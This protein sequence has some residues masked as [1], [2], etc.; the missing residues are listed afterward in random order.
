M[1]KKPPIPYLSLMRTISTLMVVLFH[2][3]YSFLEFQ[4]PGTTIGYFASPFGNWGAPFVSVFFM[5]SGAS[6]IYNHD[7]F[8]GIKDVLRFWWKRFL[9]L[10]PMFYTAWLVMYIINSNKFGSWF[11]GG[12]RRNFL[13]TLLGM[14]G[15]LMHHGRNY[16]C[17]GEW[18]LGAIIILYLLYPLLTF[19]FNHL[20]IPSTVLVVLLYVLNIN[21]NRFSSLPNTNIF[22]VLIKYYNSHIIISDNM[23]LWTCLF[24]FWMGMLA[25]EYRNKLIGFKSAALSL[26]ALILFGIFSFPISTVAANGICGIFFYLLIAYLSTYV[27]RIAVIKFLSD[28]ISRYSYGIFLVHHVIIY[29]V[30][31]YMV[32]ITFTP[33]L[34]I[35]LFIGMF[36]LIF[37]VGFVL[38][39][40][41]HR[42]MRLI[43]GALSK[44][45]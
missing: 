21:R 28:K 18:F 29:A 38:D 11:W 42:V 5:V 15:Y 36:L 32:E 3:C 23:C 44:K 27:N 33:V 31:Q 24:S 45:R 8:N 39:T 40:V 34:Q 6:L 20:R 43:S 41:V 4:I 22:I 1:Q 30:M 7:H 17:L 13:Y 14:D 12:P 2:Y 25:I 9:S 19:L 37:S 26:F 35:I 16:Y 10:F